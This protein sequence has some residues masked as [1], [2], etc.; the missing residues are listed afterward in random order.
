MRHLVAAGGG[1]QPLVADGSAGIEVRAQQG[2]GVSADRRLGPDRHAALEHERQLDALAPAPVGEARGSRCPDRSAGGPFRMDGTY[3]RFQPQACA[4][5]PRHPASGADAP[6]TRAAA[7]PFDRAGIVSSCRN[8]SW[9]SSTG[10][11]SPGT[12]S[13]PAWSRS[14]SSTSRPRPIHTFQLTTASLD[15]GGRAHGPHPRAPDRASTGSP[16]FRRQPASRAS[17]P[18][19]RAATASGGE[20]RAQ[21]GSARVSDCCHGWR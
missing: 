13:A 14:T 5:P 15:A 17:S 6:P 3:R 19:P 1:T 2:E 7:W 16:T 20:R 11:R 21:A 4:R 18:S 12:P 9:I 10:V 8:A